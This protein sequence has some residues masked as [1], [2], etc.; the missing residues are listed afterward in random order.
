[1][2]RTTLCDPPDGWK[3]RIKELQER[4]EPIDGALLLGVELALELMVFLGLDSETPLAVPAVLS[5]T[6]MRDLPLS[7][8]QR[9]AVAN[10][11]QIVPYSASSAWR[12][13][14]ARYRHLPD[15][16]RHYDFSLPDGTTGDGDG[17]I[18]LN[19]ERDHWEK[20]LI[21]VAQKPQDQRRHEVHTRLYDRCLTGRLPFHERGR[22]YASADVP[23][24]FRAELS[25]GEQRR[26]QVTFPRV[27]LD[28][29][30][31]MPAP[32]WFAPSQTRSREPMVIDIHRDLAAIAD[33]FD[34]RDKELGRRPSWRERLKHIAYCPVTSYGSID[35]S[36]KDVLRL[37]G[38]HHA[39]G[40]V[41]SGK[42]TL[43]MLIAGLFAQEHPNKR[44]TLV[45]SDVQSAI[46]LANQLN[47]Y[48]RK[49]AL[50]DTPIAI[51]ILGR[52]T[53]DK[54]L[55][56]LHESA[57]W[58]E[59]QEQGKVH[60]GE[61]FLSVSCPLQGILRA[62]DIV[63]EL[64]GRTVKPGKE[65]CGSLIP[66]P[67]RKPR[68]ATEEPTPK[69]H[70]CPLYQCCPVYRGVHDMP[71]A[72]VWITTPQ[73][74]TQ[75]RLPLQAETR[76]VHIGE[77]VYEQSD[78]LIVDEAD[79]V[80]GVLDE[81]FAQDV[82]LTN[83]QTGRGGGVFDRT[84]PQTEQFVIP[85]RATMSRG[86]L[87][88]S[89]AQ[90]GGQNASQILLALL[91]DETLPYLQRWVARDYF[92]PYSLFVRL[93]RRIACLG[94][95][96]TLEEDKEAQDRLRTA[97]EPFERLFGRGTS[98]PLN[99]VAIRR[100]HERR[101][102]V[103]EKHPDVERDEPAYELW[104][105]LRDVGVGG[106]MFGRDERELAER[107]KAWLI[108]N[109]P[110]LKSRLEKAAE[111]KRM[112]EQRDQ[113]KKPKRKYSEANAPEATVEN[114][115]TLSYRLLFALTVALLDRHTS[116]VFHEWGSRT[117]PDEDDTEPHQNTPAVLRDVLPLPPSGRQFGTYYSPGSDTP[118]SNPHRL[119]F[120]SYT[121]IGRWYLL[122]FHELLRDLTGSYGP[123]VLALSG[124][125]YLPESVRLH[126]GS[127]N[128]KPQ[129]VLLPEKS[130][131]EAIKKS[132]FTFLP[133]RGE[134]DRPIRI[135]GSPE[136]LVKIGALRTL[137]R[138]LVMDGH[139][140]AELDK[141]LNNA[142]E[143]RE[144]FASEGN[145]GSITPLWADRGRLLLLVNSYDQAKIVAQTMREVWPDERER[146]YYLAR[147]EG[148]KLDVLA[149]GKLGDVSG[150]QGSIYRPDIETFA[151]HTDGRVLIAPMNAIGRGY[152]IL[153][154]E[155]RIAAFGS[156]YFLIRP[157]PHPDDMT[158]LARE[159]NRRT[160]DWA[161]NDGFIAWEEPTVEGRFRSL[162][163]IAT[164]Y[165]DEAQ[166]RRY[167]RTLRDEKAWQCEPRK[168]LAAWTAGLLVQAV[169]RLLRGGVPFRAYFVD[170]AF[171]T[172]AAKHPD[173]SDLTDLHP[174]DSPQNS[175]LAAV[176]VQMRDLVY[177]D[178]IAR[179]L[180]EPLADALCDTLFR[181]SNFP[182]DDSWHQP[183]GA[184]K[185]A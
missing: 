112:K 164:Q 179:E 29:V 131:K 133:L 104:Q 183:V 55:R 116:I 30:Q 35:E 59:H 70:L 94:D 81:T 34:K 147:P 148:E 22:T 90:R 145:G 117:A 72:P 83:G 167:W 32:Q 127:T 144:R 44:V 107:C 157:Y 74:M 134:D 111:A 28:M 19:E 75:S 140:K 166:R 21:C 91:N 60:W 161:E 52:S 137:A 143:E 38:F 15:E 8:E 48:F 135:S 150:K 184:Q 39:A 47:I 97:F 25:D 27:L 80:M 92:S 174:V 93:A 142:H 71:H 7:E 78:L 171:A 162:R 77:I 2:S 3:Q 14:L 99:P 138:K 101:Q 106:A 95:D 33:L 139:L 84:G 69:R 24:T 185:H 26:M 64:R 124:T 12:Y 165:W 4:D 85:Q 62:D 46:R 129:G 177:N 42:S 141:L 11:R 181:D 170:A 120:L 114:L 9:S 10:V 68:R 110:G 87:R 113:Q 73:A 57:D 103:S 132:K 151:T 96:V 154:K 102:S 89:E 125:S 51:P 136:G 16:W 122:H 58:Q 126:L 155:A 79:A 6:P 65:P 41:A 88:W 53:R 149:G 130:A 178:P 49:D 160:L 123:H 13:D 56:D 50:T 153:N 54:H 61:R 23:Y 100:E 180:Y 115:D 159:M 76:P 1:M 109:N 36:N 37:D 119:S 20:R 63:K 146:I 128:T 175:L 82:D 105:L 182:F 173:V 158:A 66:P 86:Q 108:L 17:D 40:M 5:G 43:A 18:D 156:I 169:G 45:V 121:N 67:K 163:R 176:I 31:E 168:D 172:F 152:N 98:D 118:G